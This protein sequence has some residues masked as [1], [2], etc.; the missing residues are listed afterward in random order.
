MKSHLTAPL[1]PH[2]PAWPMT[3]WRPTAWLLALGL[4]ALLGA[5]PRAVQ[6]QEAVVVPEVLNYQARLQTLAG[7]DYAEGLYPIEVRIW[8]AAT[9]GTL[10]WGESY[11]VYAKG[12]RINMLLG[13]NG[14]PVSPA[15]KFAALRDVFKISG[16]SAERWLGMTV[17]ADATGAPLSSAVESSPR[18]QLLTAP[19]A[20]Q[21]QYAMYASQAGTNGSFVA[22][23]GLSVSGAR[24]TISAGLDSTA[25]LT[26]S[27]A[28]TELRSALYASG[29]ASFSN[30][31]TVVGAMTNKNGLDV[32]GPTTLR[33]GATIF[34]GI[35]GDQNFTGGVTMDSSLGKAL[36]VSP[37]L[38]Q[39]PASNPAYP[40]YNNVPDGGLWFPYNPWGGFRDLAYLSYY[41]RS[42]N[43]TP[44]TL[45][46]GIGYDTDDNLVLKA[47]GTNEIHATA[48]TADVGSVSGLLGS[49]S[50]HM[51][52]FYNTDQYNKT[53]QSDGFIVLTGWHNQLSYAVSFAGDGW[54]IN[55]TAYFYYDT[56][57]TVQMTFPLRQ[58]GKFW[59]QMHWTASSTYHTVEIWW[60]P[61]GTKK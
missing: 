25:G 44:A 34:G 31:V 47:S 23:N 42:A 54:D 18:Q 43:G 37:S 57:D 17:K 53:V 21:S 3:P 32:S 1:N 13:Q 61:M 49:K 24:T 40:I 2:P 38:H 60:I 56:A 14:T 8:S 16:G 46:L 26:V 28:P 51:Q 35:N 50:E 4:F 36:V 52:L 33:G 19:F 59:A 5:A 39:Y 29:P 48:L 30:S 12:G 10:L 41:R 15:G 55:T 20:Y 11:R 6:A 27:G 7:A 45:E 22:A 9:G 58:G